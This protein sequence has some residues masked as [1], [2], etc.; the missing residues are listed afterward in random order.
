VFIINAIYFSIHPC[1]TELAKAAGFL[2]GMLALIAMF[3]TALCDGQ[4]R[5]SR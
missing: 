2:S 1:I 4:P 3:A 5:K